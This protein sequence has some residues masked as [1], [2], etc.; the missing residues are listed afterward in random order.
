[1][2][3][4]FRMLH[5]RF[6]FVTCHLWVLFDQKEEL[7]FF[8]NQSLGSGW[9]SGE[10]EEALNMEARMCFALALLKISPCVWPEKNSE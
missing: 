8:F 9:A 5:R 4:S 7:F 2:D 3:S 10:L 1:M 6:W